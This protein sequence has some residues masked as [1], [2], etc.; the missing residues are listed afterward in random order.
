MTPNICEYPGPILTYFTGLVV[1]DE[2]PDIRLGVAQGTLL[3][4]HQLNFEGLVDL[5]EGY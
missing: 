5:Y 1:R 4:Q 3:W 2:Y